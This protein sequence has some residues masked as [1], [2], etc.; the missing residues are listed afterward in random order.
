MCICVWVQV[1]LET[2]NLEVQGAALHGNRTWVL[3]ESGD[4]S[5]FLRKAFCSLLLE[6]SSALVLDLE[7]FSVSWHLVEAKT[8]VSGW[9]KL[10]PSA[11]SWHWKWSLFPG[12]HFTAP[13][14]VIA[15]LVFHTSL[16]F[17][18]SKAQLIKLAFSKTAHHASSLKLII[19][20]KMAHV[21]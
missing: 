14:W 19:F 15:A 3:S 10:L 21:V 16:P 20:R 6:L 11:P 17:S 1:T 8:K 4:I 7:N 2:M 13:K 18:Y 12:F 5:S 9:R